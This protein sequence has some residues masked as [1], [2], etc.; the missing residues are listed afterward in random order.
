[1]GSFLSI[2]A[3]ITIVGTA[4][5]VVVSIIGTIIALTDP[6]PRKDSQEAAAGFLIAFVVSMYYLGVLSWLYF[7]YPIVP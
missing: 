3:F 7:T 6:N 4:I 2:I 5:L 1:M